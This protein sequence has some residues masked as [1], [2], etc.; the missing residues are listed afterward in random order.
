MI[1]TYQRV[2]AKCRAP[3]PTKTRPQSRRSTAR[4]AR[5]A[6]MAELT[7]YEKPT[8]TTCRNLA[9]LLRERGVDYDAVAYHVFGVGGDEVGELVRKPGEP[10]RE[11]FRT[12]E[13]IYAE[14][15]LGDREVSD[16]EAI[17]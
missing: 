12:R 4:R 11:R 6:A 5:C 13:S 9:E 8:C 7:I 1:E 17:A 3:A 16:D 10:A 2:C 15:G 14:L